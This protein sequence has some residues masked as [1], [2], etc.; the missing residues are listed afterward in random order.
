MTDFDLDL[1]GLA[2]VAEALDDLEDDWSDAP[3]F[4]IENTA[5]Y[6][7]ILEFGRGP[8]TSNGDD[9]LTFKID[10]QWVSTHRVSGHPPYPF[11]RPA[12]RGFKRDPKGFVAR[13]S[14]LGLLEA[15]TV[16][17]LLLNITTA[18]NSQMQTNLR[19]SATGR[20]LGTKPMHPQVQTGNLLNS[21][22]W[23]RV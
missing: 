23:D 9:P 8:I 19:A 16:D 15:D 22:G 13:N 2:D 3:T 11:F 14:R 12:I 21:Q 20:S 10:G 1:D 5:D 17:E 6:A 18:I 4:K 7:P